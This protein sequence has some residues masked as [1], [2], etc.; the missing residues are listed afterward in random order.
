MDCVSIIKYVRLVSMAYNEMK[1]LKTKIQFNFNVDD[2]EIPEFNVD[3]KLK[4]RKKVKNIKIIE[5]KRKKKVIDAST[6]LF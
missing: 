1:N 2:I 6:K 5:H 3:M 4:T